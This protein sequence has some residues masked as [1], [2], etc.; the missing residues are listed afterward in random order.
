MS[1]KLKVQELESRI[2]PSIGLLGFLQGLAEADSSFGEIFNTVVDGDGN[3]DT[4]MAADVVNNSD[5][6]ATVAPVTSSFNLSNIV[7]QESTAS[8]IL[9][10]LGH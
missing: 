6:G 5:L 4:G 10:A 2:A 1:R 8:A 9:A 7:I 3:V